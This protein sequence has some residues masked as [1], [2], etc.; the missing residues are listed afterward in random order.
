M[1]TKSEDIQ[2][3]LQVMFEFKERLKLVGNM[4]ENMYVRGT[5]GSIIDIE[6]TSLQM[7]KLLELMFILLSNKFNFRGENS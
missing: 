5:K 4:C 2:K 6:N 3:Y 1:E 7:R